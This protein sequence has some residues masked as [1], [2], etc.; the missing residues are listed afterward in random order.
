MFAMYFCLA[1]T[2]VWSLYAILAQLKE[3]GEPNL[4]ED[5]R[6]CNILNLSD[7]E[8]SC[9]VFSFWEK[10]VENRIIENLMNQL[11]QYVHLKNAEE[12]W[13]KVLLLDFF[14]LW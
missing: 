3:Q 12:S 7:K 11:T 9:R 5:Y 6:S 1:D 2:D 10:T 13:Q 4:Y 14:R 8:F